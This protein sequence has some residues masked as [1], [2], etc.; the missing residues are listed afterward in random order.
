MYQASK[1]FQN[2]DFNSFNNKSSSLNKNYNKIADITYRSQDNNLDYRNKGINYPE[3][4]IADIVYDN[5]TNDT[6]I[7]KIYKDN[8]HEASSRLESIF[9]RINN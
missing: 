7:I 4:K 5:N 9:D 2:D 3:R 6:K 8:K 1:Q